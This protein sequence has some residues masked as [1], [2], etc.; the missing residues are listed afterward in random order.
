MMFSCREYDSLCSVFATLALLFFSFEAM[1]RWEEQKCFVHRACVHTIVHQKTK[2]PF[3]QGGVLIY[4][5]K[6]LK[7]HFLFAKVCLTLDAATQKV[8]FL[9]HNMEYKG[10]SAVYQLVCSLLVTFNCFSCHCVT[11]L[12][13]AC[14]L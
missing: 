9:T 3:L 14:N 7:Y 11:V 12:A 10:L 2:M 4:P 13:E 1:R 5:L 8:I 6:Q